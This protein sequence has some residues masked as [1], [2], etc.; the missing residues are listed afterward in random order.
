MSQFIALDM[1]PSGLTANELHSLLSIFPG[2]VRVEVLIDRKGRS[3][4][5]AMV[6]VG[7]GAYGDVI[8]EALDGLELFGRSLRASRLDV[9]EMAFA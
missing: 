4:C 7:T 8:M 2:V 5:S 3:L 9:P 1:L 6:E